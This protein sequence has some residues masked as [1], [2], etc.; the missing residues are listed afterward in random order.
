MV[1][2]WI[3]LNLTDLAQLFLRKNLEKGSEVNGQH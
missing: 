1:I 3:Q 2:L